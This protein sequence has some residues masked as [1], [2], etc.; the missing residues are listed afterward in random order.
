MGTVRVV[1][2]EPEA[3]DEGIG[4]SAPVAAAMA[5]AVEVVRRLVASSAL[6]VSATK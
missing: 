4:L 3:L 5:P 1:G 6:A 2:C